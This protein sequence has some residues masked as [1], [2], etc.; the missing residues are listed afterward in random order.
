MISSALRCPFLRVTGTISTI[1]Y[2]MFKGFRKP[3]ASSEK[4]VGAIELGGTFLS[5]A[6]V[7]VQ[8]NN[9]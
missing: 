2:F 1:L 6:I 8:K 3:I 4:I 9:N 7:K 5:L